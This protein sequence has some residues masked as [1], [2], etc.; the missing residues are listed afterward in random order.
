MD[1]VD[2]MLGALVF[3]AACIVFSLWYKATHE[4]KPKRQID[5]YVPV[6][7]WYCERCGT[8]ITDSRHLTA[9]VIPFCP[10]DDLPDEMIPEDDFV[11]WE[12]SL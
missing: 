2:V 7:I 8:P 6:W 1:G 9:G 12:K 5:Y 3:L 4:P 11:Q 10:C